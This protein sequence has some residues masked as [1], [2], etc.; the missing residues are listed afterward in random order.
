[1]RLIASRAVSA[2]AASI[3]VALPPAKAQQTGQVHR[4][5]IVAAS[6]PVAE[7]TEARDSF[8]R[9]LFP[10]LRRLGYTEGQNLVVE[11]WSAAGRR[12]SYPDVAREARDLR[13]NGP[14][15]TG[16]PS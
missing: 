6:G 9:D 12:E 15:S 16:G 13:T 8:L 10:E 7:M 2:L 11:R 14:R 4:I 1:M 3:L 5:A